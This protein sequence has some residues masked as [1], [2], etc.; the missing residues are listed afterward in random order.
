MR[1]LAL[2][3]LFSLSLFA[4]ESR[5]NISLEKTKFYS[6][7]QTSSAIRGDLELKNKGLTISLKAIHD[8]ED[9][10]RRYIDLQELNYTFSY[11]DYD[12][13]VGKSIKFWGSLELHNPTD[14]FNQKDILDDITDKDKKLGSWNIS[15]SKY[16]DDDELSLIVKLKESYQDYSRVGYTKYFKSEKSKYRPTI[17]LKY[18]G[19]EG[20]RDFAYILM[21][22]YDS[23]RDTIFDKGELKSYLYLANKF[24][25]Y[26]TLVQGDTIYKAEFAYTDVKNYQTIKDYYEYGLGVE[27]TFYSVWDKKDLGV[28]AE[29]YKSNINRKIIFQNDLFIGARLSFN[30]TASSEIVGGVIRDFDS[31][32]NSYSLEVKKRIFDKY[33]LNIRYIK[34]ETKVLRASVGYYF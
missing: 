24:L 22:G 29:F 23:F 1:K 11:G 30:D 7:S 2:L 31:D 25:T 27:K 17:F 10:K 8:R 26:Q 32:K 14:I 6:P 9:K 12:F 33:M 21:S 4:W 5:G 20:D 3:T 13:S 18:S 15:A 19:S 34:D 16:I 28:L